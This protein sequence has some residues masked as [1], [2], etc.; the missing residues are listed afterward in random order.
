MARKVAVDCTNNIARVHVKNGAFAKAK[1]CCV[2]C[3]KLDGGN[4]SAL[5]IAANVCAE[6]GDF[7]EAAASLKAANDECAKEANKDHR[8][9]VS[10]CEQ[11]VRRK[12]L[13]YKEKEKAMSMKMMA[14]AEKK[15]ASSESASSE[16]ASSAPAFAPAAT[17]AGRRAGMV[18]KKGA[19]G[20]GYYSDCLDYADLPAAGTGAAL[21]SAGLL[22]N[23]NWLAVCAIAMIVAAWF[24]NMRFPQTN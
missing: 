15:S 5:V 23:A 16:S 4:V 1:E 18:F 19:L 24:V 17:F 3:L 12:K 9:S 14:P 6:M 22:P 2:E 21:S 11:T 13:A 8:L 20:V 10:K 7:G